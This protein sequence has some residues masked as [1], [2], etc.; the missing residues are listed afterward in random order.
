MTNEEER[1]KLIQAIEENDDFYKNN[2]EPLKG[3]GKSLEEDKLLLKGQLPIKTARKLSKEL[4]VEERKERIRES[5]NKA[6][7]RNGK[8]LERLSKAREDNQD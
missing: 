3:L 8:A 4:Q 5:Y 2:N 7:K 6:V 1:K